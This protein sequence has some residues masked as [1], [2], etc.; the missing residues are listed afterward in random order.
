MLEKSSRYF[1]SLEEEIF[2]KGF[3]RGV[4]NVNLTCY[5]NMKKH[6]KEPYPDEIEHFELIKKY[7]NQS[8]DMIARHVILESEVYPFY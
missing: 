1:D 2:L 4:I 3:V 8:A 5:R 6:H 7:D